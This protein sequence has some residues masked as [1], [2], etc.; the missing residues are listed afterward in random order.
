MGK[1]TKTNQAKTDQLGMPFGTASGRLKKNV[2]YHLLCKLKENFCFQCGGEILNVTKLSIEH[3]K[4]WLHVNPELFWDISNIAFS[5]LSCNSAAARP[6]KERPWNKANVI[7]GK[8]W[9]SACRVYKCVTLFGKSKASHTGTHGYCR[10]CRKRR[11]W[12][13]KVK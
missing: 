13:H 10:D 1:K 3:K 6:R 2:L 9:C 4:P 7:P 11:G 5:H 12:G 8:A